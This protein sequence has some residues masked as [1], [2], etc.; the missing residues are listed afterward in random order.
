MSAL[1]AIIPKPSEYRHTIANDAFPGL[2]AGAMTS[3]KASIKTA[4]GDVEIAAKS[5]F[6]SKPRARRIVPK[7]TT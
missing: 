1:G 2:M 6:V 4:Y 5:L 3:A 7:R